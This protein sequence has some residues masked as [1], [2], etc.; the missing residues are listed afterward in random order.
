[1]DYNDLIEDF[2]SFRYS[3]MS[4]CRCTINDGSRIYSLS[5]LKLFLSRVGFFDTWSEVIMSDANMH[6]NR[7]LIYRASNGVFGLSVKDLFNKHKEY[8]NE[9]KKHK[10]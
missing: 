9:N 1:M 4:Y 3:M 6:T 2:D 7:D 8:I 5:L 10:N